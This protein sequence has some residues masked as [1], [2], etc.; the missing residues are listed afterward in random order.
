MKINNNIQALNAYRNLSQNQFHTSK[1]LEKLSSGLR[2]NRAADD[3]AGLAIS[4]N[5][6]AQ[7]RGMNVVLIEHYFNF[8]GNFCNSIR[9]FFNLRITKF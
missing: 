9:H 6:N 5:L 7:I 2:I 3:A 1:N 8:F 4:E